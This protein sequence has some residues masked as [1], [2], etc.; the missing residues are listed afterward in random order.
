MQT[1]GKTDVHPV[2]EILKSVNNFGYGRKQLPSTRD[3]EIRA[4]IEASGS[5]QLREEI[6]LDSAPVLRVFAERAASLAVRNADWE[7][8][9][10]GLIA[11][12][13]AGLES[14]ESLLVLVLYCDAAKRIA[15]D[16][17]L[18]FGGVGNLLGEAVL[19]HLTRFLAR[20]PQDKSLQSMGYRA[21]GAA[22]E[23]R[24]V[25]SW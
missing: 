4:Y 5:Q 21:E 6:P 2:P 1:Y 8:L 7:L 3:D 12:A 9:R 13:K 20:A 19:G 16:E 25:R 23:F 18:L 10:A 24:Y 14:R 11:L 17:R 15:I 22:A